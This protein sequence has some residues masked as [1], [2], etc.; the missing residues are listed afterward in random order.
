MKTGRSK[1]ERKDHLRSSLEAEVVKSDQTSHLNASLMQ[2]IAAM[3]RRAMTVWTALLLL[4]TT[5][6]AVERI[7]PLLISSTCS[8]V[9]RRGGRGGGLK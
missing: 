7:A 8:S 6:T 9:F 2:P 1:R 4:A 3:K 5:A